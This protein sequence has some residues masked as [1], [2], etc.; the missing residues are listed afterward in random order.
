MVLNKH[1]YTAVIDIVES[2]DSVLLLRAWGHINTQSA[3]PFEAKAFRTIDQSD[4][5]VV[6]E[7]SG[8]T[9]L[10]TA[11]LRVF[12]RLWKQLKDKGHALY[13]CNLKPYIN[14]IFEL[15]GFDRVIDIHSDVESALAF[16]GSK[17]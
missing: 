3:A 14:Q 9:Y 2:E 8:V 15:L 1:S 17:P 11:G 6:I 4:S 7:A 10:S 13:I 12:I 5:D 16:A